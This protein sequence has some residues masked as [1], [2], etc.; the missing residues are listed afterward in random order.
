M[1]FINSP[2]AILDKN[3]KALDY[4]KINLKYEDYLVRENDNYIKE[5]F[6]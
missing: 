5:D 2:F 3:M 1:K 6:K 4:Q